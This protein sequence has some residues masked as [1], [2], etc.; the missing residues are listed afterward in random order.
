MVRETRRRGDLLLLS[1]EERKMRVGKEEEKE[2][3]SPDGGCGYN[4]MDE[5]SDASP[6]AAD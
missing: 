4:S 3:I 1:R 5:T 6:T 2:M